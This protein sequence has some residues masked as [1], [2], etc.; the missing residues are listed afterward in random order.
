MILRAPIAQIDSAIAK[1]PTDAAE[2][3]RGQQEVMTSWA[4][5]FVSPMPSR[6]RAFDRSEEPALTE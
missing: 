4:T 6:D 3:Q 2:D 5:C 1:I